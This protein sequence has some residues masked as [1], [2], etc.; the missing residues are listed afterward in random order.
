VRWSPDSRRLAFLVSP[1]GKA[2]DSHRV[3]IGVVARDGGPMRRLGVVGAAFTWSPDGRWIALASGTNRD[4]HVQKSTLLLARADGGTPIDL[5]PELDGDAAT[6]AWSPASD[7]LH[8]HAARGVTSVHAAVPARGGPVRFGRDREA[9]AGTPFAAATGRVAWVQSGPRAPAEIW[10]AD[11]PGGPGRP[12]TSLHSG[13]ARL[14]FGDTR[15]VGWTSDDGTTVEGLLLRPP[16]AAAKARLPTLVQLH[17]GP[18]GSRNSLGFQ[19]LPQYLAA[20][21]YQVFMPNF[22]S[23]GGYG[24]RF[25]V[26]RRAD[27]GGQDWRDVT[28]GVDEL[29]R[30]GLADSTKLGV[31][32]RSYGGYLTAWATTQTRRFDAACVFAGAVDLG[33]LY[34][35]SDVQ[36]YRAWEFQGHPWETESWRR[37]SPITYIAQARTP[38]LIQIGENDLRVPY[39]QAQQHY[40]ALLALG[41][42]TQFVH[43]PRE[44]HVLREP[45]HRADFMT[46]MLA[47]WKQW[48]R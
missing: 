44:G 9:E 11:R 8:F 16:E 13:I 22:R 31:F 34:G 23:S 38:T 39:P 19:P 7:S 36:R 10:I 4:V 27:W 18:Y 40:R 15:V 1:T 3:D 25:L 24:T 6:P 20:A 21:G 30:R 35:Q 12:L 5:T 28:T 17:G 45:R 47:W 2:D 42:P 14:S 29:I 26:R 46:R 37:A 48:I 43:Y 33:A 41:V 32:G